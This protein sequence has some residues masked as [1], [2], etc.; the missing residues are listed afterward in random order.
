MGHWILRCRECNREWRILVS[1]P[2]K[3]E[4]KQLYHYCENC[5][6]NTFHDILEYKEEE[7]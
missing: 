6:K 2:L 1:F 4:F 7:D 5:G 3:K